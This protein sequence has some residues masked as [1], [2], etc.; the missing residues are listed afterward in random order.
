ML[1]DSQELPV[2][3][4]KN[5]D[6]IIWFT[7]DAITIS[8]IRAVVRGTT[9]SVTVNPKFAADR[10]AAGT[11]ILTAAEAVTNETTGAN[12]SL[13]NTSIAAGQWVWLETTAQSGTVSELN[14]TIVYTRD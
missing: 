8:Q 5:E 13:N 12:L 7:P 3:I 14:L 6:I 1:P 11:A 4:R 10:S 2:P 9:P